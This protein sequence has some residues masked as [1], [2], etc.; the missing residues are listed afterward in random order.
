MR[1]PA[2]SLRHSGVSYQL[3]HEISQQMSGGFVDM[4]RLIHVAGI[5]RDLAQELVRQMRTGNVDA[6]ALAARGL[7]FKAAIAITEV[8]SS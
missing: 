8:I 4:E 7:S 2:I 3:A 6:G 1:A 5:D